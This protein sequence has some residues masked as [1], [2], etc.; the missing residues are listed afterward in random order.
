LV[1]VAGLQ[2]DIV[3][4]KTHS[5]GSQSGTS[6]EKPAFAAFKQFIQASDIKVLNPYLF[7]HADEQPTYYPD[8]LSGLTRALVSQRRTR[9][10][11]Y[12][13]ALEASAAPAVKALA[14]PA[15]ALLTQYTS[16]STTKTQ[17]RTA[18]QQA[19]G[20]IGPAALALAEALWDVH[21]AALYAHRRQ[22]V[23]A[24]QY[25]DYAHLPN[26]VYPKKDTPAPSGL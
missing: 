10:A 15:R 17:T 21:T 26:R 4:R 7:D 2:V 8:G 14:A 5:G 16:A 9:L 11:A 1:A 13:K 3:T 20:D 23:Q 18:L 25:F 24:R 6:A 12:T 22:P 19:I